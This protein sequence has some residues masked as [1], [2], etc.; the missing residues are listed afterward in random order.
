[1]LHSEG[2]HTYCTLR[3]ITLKHIKIAVLT[4]SIAMTGL[5]YFCKRLLVMDPFSN[6]PLINRVTLMV[7]SH[8]TQLSEFIV[9]L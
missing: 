1:M 5:H 4:T 7:L 3:F 2:R 8:L 6:Q 9:H